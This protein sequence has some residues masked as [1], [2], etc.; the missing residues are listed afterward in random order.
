MQNGGRIIRALFEIAM[1]RRAATTALVL[2]S[3]SKAIEKRLWPYDHPLRQFE[4]KQD[5]LYNLGRFADDLPISDLA[6]SNPDDLGVLLHM[7]RT[8]GQALLTAARQF[9]AVTIHHEL[10]PL[11]HDLLEVSLRLERT[12]EWNDRLHGSSLPFWVWAEDHTG[13]QILQFANVLLRPTTSVFKLDFVVPIKGSRPPFISIRV[14]SDHW[15]GAEDTLEIDLDRLVMPPAST[16][17][18]TLLDLPFLPL[19][20][21]ADARLKNAY[22]EISSLNAIQ[23]QAFW[24]LYHSQDNVLLCGPSGSGKSTMGEIAAWC[25][26][27]RSAF[28]P[29]K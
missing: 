29:R 28:C 10:R 17:H 12:F 20:S 16:A 25:V 5:V 18:T 1:S 19:G 23:T 13:S 11:S 27:S 6:R 15:M 9:P 3:L 8:H 2:L 7:N 4:L 24:P 21:L 22:P 14:C 26:G